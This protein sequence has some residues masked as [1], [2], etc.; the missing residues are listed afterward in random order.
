MMICQDRLGTITQENIKEKGVFRTA[1][2]VGVST[3]TTPSPEERSLFM[4]A[5]Q[6][7]VTPIIPG[8]QAPP[9]APGPAATPFSSVSA[10]MN[11]CP[12]PVLANQSFRFPSESRVRLKSGSA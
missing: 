10:F 6:C 2:N 8:I 3:F 4:K 9:F 12:E 11:V 5:A 1:R 7:S